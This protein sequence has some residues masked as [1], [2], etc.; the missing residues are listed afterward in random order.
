MNPKWSIVVKEILG[1][2][3]V[4]LIVSFIMKKIGWLDVD[5]SII[6]Y[7]TSLTCGW[8]ILKG[9][10]YFVKHKKIIMFKYVI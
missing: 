3:I 5:M 8:G 6:L 10:I 1:Y 9:I 7:A 4:V 2:F